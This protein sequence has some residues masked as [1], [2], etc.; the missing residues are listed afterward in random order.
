MTENVNHPMHYA[1]GKYE[2]IKVMLEIYGKEPV[3]NFCECNAFKYLWRCHRK[4]G[5][6]DRA[7]AIWYLTEYIKISEGVYD[8]EN[9][10]Q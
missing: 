5:N 1:T 7:K 9:N 8:D 6:E 3:L 4:N 10:A 2:C